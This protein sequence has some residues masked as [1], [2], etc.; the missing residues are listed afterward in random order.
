MSGD[1]WYNMVVNITPIITI[2]VKSQQLSQPVHHLVFMRH[3]AMNVAIERNRGV[4]MPEDLR[5]C[6]YVHPALQC[7]GG[8]SMP[9]GVKAPVRNF[10]AS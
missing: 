8:K 6:F 2:D 9:E 5:K 1:I 7:T 10:K 3:E 4:L